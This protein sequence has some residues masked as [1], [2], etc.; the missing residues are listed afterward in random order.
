MKINHEWASS[1]QTIG[2][3][4]TLYI[5]KILFENTGNIEKNKKNMQFLS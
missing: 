4:A 3:L 5:I 2:S 1:P